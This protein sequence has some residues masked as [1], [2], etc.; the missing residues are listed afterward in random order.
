MLISKDHPTKNIACGERLTYNAEQSTW[1]F[2]LRELLS[3]WG[4]SRS[5]TFF[6]WKVVE[7]FI[8]ISPLLK[9]ALHNVTTQKQH[10]PTVCNRLFWHLYTL[11]S[12]VVLFQQWLYFGCLV[13]CF[14]S[15]FEMFF[16]INSNLLSMLDPFFYVKLWLHVFTLIFNY[17]IMSFWLEVCMFILSL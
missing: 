13:D 8:N 11:Y 15:W 7:S 1:F 5:K 14:W 10:C 16:L 6:Y 12:G 17:S 3:S 9:N 4:R 2:Y